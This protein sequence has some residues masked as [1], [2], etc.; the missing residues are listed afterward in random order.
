MKGGMCLYHCY[1]PER[2]EKKAEEILAKYKDGALLLKPQAM[3]VDDFAEFY[4]EATI[5][6]AYLSSD[7]LTLGL[8]CFN[9]GKLMVWDETR[10]KEYPIDVLKGYIFIDKDVLETE[11]EGRIRFTIIHEC[12]HYI[13]H[14]RFYYQKSGSVIPKIECTVYHIEQWDKRPPMTDDDTREWQANR[15]G[16]A[17]IMPAPT[18]RMLMAERLGVAVDTLTAVRVSDSLIEDMA[19]VFVVSKSAMKN[20][21]R[22]LDLL[23]Q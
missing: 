7:G 20:R 2:L 22:D 15:L 8:T 1:T 9:D 10:T 3:D 16:A 13:L 23:L 17:L 11:V 21:L 14:P 18:M 4:C 6:F 19:A 5:D 12:S